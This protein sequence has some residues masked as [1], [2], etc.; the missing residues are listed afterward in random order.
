MR[1]ETANRCVESHRVDVKTM[2]DQSYLPVFYQEVTKVG[3][4]YRDCYRS[5]PGEL[6]IDALER[7]IAFLQ[8]TASTVPFFAT[9]PDY[10]KDSIL[11]NI[12]NLFLGGRVIEPLSKVAPEKQDT[13]EHSII[14]YG[15]C[16]AA[17]GV[18]LLYCL[19][20]VRK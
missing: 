17:F 16:A 20:R 8:N 3:E 15:I 18:A 5:E 13:A 1:L 19:I 7:E 6:Q 12:R 14:A 11:D 10:S 2:F 9:L 4:V